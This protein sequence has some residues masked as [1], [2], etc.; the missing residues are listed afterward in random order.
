MWKRIDLGVKATAL[1]VVASFLPYIDV[2]WVSTGCANEGPNGG[3]LSAVAIVAWLAGAV[4]LVV[5]LARARRDEKT[6][7]DLLLLPAIGASLLGFVL[8]VGHAFASDCGGGI[9]W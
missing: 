4:L 6:S 7:R 3:V 8:L 5:A 2:R 9:V 1:I